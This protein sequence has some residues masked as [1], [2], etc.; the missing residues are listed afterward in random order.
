MSSLQGK[1]EVKV[2]K[3]VMNLK[4]GDQGQELKRLKSEKAELRK[5]LINRFGKQTMKFKKAVTRL[6]TLSRM[7]EKESEVKFGNKLSH[8]KKKHSEVRKDRAR[9]LKDYVKS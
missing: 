4:I 8:L 9:E 7:A 2:I 5:E 3:T 6:N 1:G